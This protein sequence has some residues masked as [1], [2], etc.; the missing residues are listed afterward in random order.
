MKQEEHSGR[1]VKSLD[2]RKLLFGVKIE[3]QRDWL[4]KPQFEEIGIKDDGTTEE[5][6]W[7]KLHGKYGYCHIGEGRILIP[8]V[9]GCPLFFGTNAQAVAWKDYKVGVI[10]Q[11]NQVLIPFIYDDLNIRYRRVPIPDEEGKYKDVFMGYACFTNDGVSQAYD[12]NCQLA[13]F[14]DGE[15]ELLNRETEYDN[16][17]VEDMSL[18]EL[19]ERIKK[20]YVTLFELGYQ[21]YCDKAWSQEHCVKV[22]A[23]EKKVKSLLADR[24]QMMNRSFV[25][26]MESA[27]RIKRTNDL[28]TRA[29]RKAIKLGK[30]TSESL[31]WMEKVSHT[32]HY[33]VGIYVYPKWKNSKSDLRYERKYKS[34]DKEKERL[35]AELHNEEG[36]HIWNIIAALASGSNYYELHSCCNHWASKYTPDDWDERKI[37]MD[38]GASWDDGMHYPVYQDVY[39]TYPWYCLH[40]HHFLYSFEDLCNINDFI[41]NVEVQFVTR[42]QDRVW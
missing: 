13:T 22:N 32:T 7:F 8:A 38:D 12:E 15:L 2:K 6:V 5:K 25:H 36:T 30:K 18:A 31:Q 24:Q 14:K 4:I 29:I 21:H 42:E 34:S 27:R 17:E 20:E 40:N 16:P 41:V 26:N 37:T 10:N 3:G 1:Y 28:L 19:E 35:M 11:E 23:Q 9:Y 33:E 39:F